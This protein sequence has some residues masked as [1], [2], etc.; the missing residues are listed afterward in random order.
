MS[1]SE[2]QKWRAVAIAFGKMAVCDS[3]SVTPDQ[4]D[5]RCRI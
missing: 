1:S 5:Q 4:V 2:Q 3:G